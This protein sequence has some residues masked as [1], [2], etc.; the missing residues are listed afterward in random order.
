MRN[1]N[2]DNLLQQLIDTLQASGEQ[3][4]ADALTRLRVQLDAW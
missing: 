3:P 4:L 2:L 1:N